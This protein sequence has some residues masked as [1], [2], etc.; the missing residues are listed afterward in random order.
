MA[1]DAISRS[2]ISNG[3]IE[4]VQIILFLWVPIL[5]IHS[6]GQ[7]LYNSIYIVCLLHYFVVM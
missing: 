5:H 4:G 1:M 3:L 6:S 7:L 2:F